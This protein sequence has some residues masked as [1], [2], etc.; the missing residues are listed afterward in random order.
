M[1]RPNNESTFPEFDEAGNMITIKKPKKIEELEEEFEEIIN[2][3]KVF[4]CQHCGK[5]WI[6][7]I[8]RIRHESWC[9]KNPD[10]RT[11]YKKPKTEPVKKPK[12]KAQSK[13]KISKEKDIIKELRKFDKD[14]GL[15]DKQIV[16]YIRDK[17]KG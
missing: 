5:E 3:K 1:T 12:K 11:Y 8:S 6:S 4:N 17:I 10:C 9:P 16:K 13:T 7:D 15:T 2:G 14:F